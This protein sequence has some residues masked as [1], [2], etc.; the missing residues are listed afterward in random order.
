LR[1]QHCPPPWSGPA[2]T[3]DPPPRG[4]APSSQSVQGPRPVLQCATQCVVERV[5]HAIPVPRIIGGNPSTAIP[6]PRREPSRDRAGE[7][8]AR[9]P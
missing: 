9:S 6:H 1:A 7:S 8:G 4:P 2:P 5:R 3:L